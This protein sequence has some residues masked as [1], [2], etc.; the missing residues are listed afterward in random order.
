[1]RT[2]HSRQAAR[3]ASTLVAAGLVLSAAPQALAADDG[4]MTLTDAQA[5]RLAQDMGSDV[6]GGVQDDVADDV[7]DAGTTGTTDGTSGT[8]GTTG[9]TTP[10]TFTQR[11]AREGVR[12][13]GVTIPASGRQYF[14]VHGLGNVELHDADGSTVW[15][16]GN[17]SLRADWKVTPARPWEREMYPARVV[18]GYD[19][20]SPF[21]TGSDDGYTTGDLTGD[22]TADLV[23][24]ASLG[25][26]PPVGA[27]FPGTNLN[28]GTEVTVLDG[29]TGATVWSKAYAFASTVKVVGDTLLVADTPSANGWAP[30]GSTA[31]LTGTRFTV[32]DGALTPSETWTFDPAVTGEVGWGDLT[33]LGDG[34]VA[35]SWNLRK[36]DTAAGQGH[37]MVLDVADGSVVWQQESDLYSRQLHLDPARGRVVAL[38]QADTRDAV[39][40]QVVSYGLTDGE[41]TVLNTRVNALPTAMTIGDAASGDGAEYIVA[42][43]TL[44]AVRYINASTIRVLDGDDGSTAKWTVTTK[45]DAAN[46]ADG[47]SVWSLDVAG[48]L[49]VASSQD[50]KDINEADNVAGLRYGTLSAYTS[51][52]R[53]KWR[54]DG[55]DASPRFQ[56]V[57]TSGKAAVVRVVDQGQNIRTYKLGN[58]R[59]TDLTPL[60]GDLN[61]G[62]TVDLDGDGK[63]DVVAGGSSHGVWA[64]K[65]TS[66][67]KGTPKELWRATVPGEIHRV[68][69]GDVNGDGRPEVVVAADTATVVLDG[70]TGNVLTTID[71]AGQYVR[72]VTVADV[73]G[74]GKDEV[75]VPTDAVRAY[76]ARGRVLWTYAAPTERTDVVFGDVQ[77]DR[78]TVY[79]QY[80]TE[81]ALW[82]DA[83]SVGGTA[84]DGTTGE[85]RWHV[86]PDAPA[87]A[88]DGKIHGAVLDHGVFASPKIAFADGNAVVYTWIIMADP[89]VTGAEAASTATVVVEIRDGRTGEL[90]QQDISGSPWSHGN[91]F[92]DGKN[93]PLYLLSFGSFSGYPGDGTVTHGSV[94]APAR[95]AQFVTG[96]AG[97]RLVLTGLEGGVAAYDPSQLDNVVPFQ[98]SIGITG[99]MGARTFLADD[100]DGDGVDDVVSLNYDHLGVNRM[101]AQLGGGV[102]SLD[103]GIHQLTTF[104]LS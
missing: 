73:N 1:M 29:K 28:A 59:A 68:E 19:A 60:Q 36:S 9:G 63:D 75:V 87:Q 48:G 69:H 64:W 11:S 51:A 72:T 88:M 25:I 17:T 66:L 10:V 22:G 14:S 47:P 18:M 27:R 34:T 21:S 35:T 50:D 42:E 13:L 26:E 101:A 93:D 100:L 41:R 37:T 55:T 90:L 12:G 6:Y 94:T 4:A 98:P 86:T 56:Q 44:D 99:P 104:T 96:P 23:F 32:A 74:D 77:V 46:G 30:D 80:T 15:E 57:D 24:S 61:A 103:G 53:L 79:A 95:T 81:D 2:T 5:D 43:S 20:V 67:V 83:P 58:G 102:L 31:T 71:G 45:R 70:A 92:I 7:E 39:R 38:E 85:P 84:L 78:G 49:L 91:F 97:R 76:D 65:G 40:Y 3:L 62:T 8:S 82:D 54:A 16:R 33:D 52:G 89:S